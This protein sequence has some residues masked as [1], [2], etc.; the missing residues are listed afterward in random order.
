MTVNFTKNDDF[1]Q[2]LSA[3]FAPLERFEEKCNI[4]FDAESNG[5]QEDV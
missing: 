2:S 1:R 4:R 3:C 5:L